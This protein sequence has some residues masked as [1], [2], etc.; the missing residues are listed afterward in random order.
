[1]PV[2]PP[3]SAGT[4]PFLVRLPG[5]DDVIHWYPESALSP[6]ERRHRQRIRMETM[7][8]SPTPEVVSKLSEIGQE[9]D[10]VQDALVTLSVLGRL[11]VKATGRAIPGL[12]WVATAADTLNVLNKFYPPNPLRAGKWAARMEAKRQLSL[13]SQLTAG[14][15]KQRLLDTLKTG[16]LGFGW[17]EAVQVLQT[18]DWLTG[19]G[20][21]LGPIFGAMSDTMF[22]LARG[23]EFDFTGPAEVI[24]STQIAQQSAR[25]D[26]FLG[27]PLS[28]ALPP[29]AIVPIGM[30]LNAL[31]W[32][33]DTVATP[34]QAYDKLRVTWPGIIPLIDL[35]TFAKPGTTEAEI[36][37]L[38]SPLVG[39]AKAGIIAVLSAFGATQKALTMGAVAAG[40]ALGWLGGYRDDLWWEDHVDLAMGSALLVNILRPYMHRT[41]WGAIAAD[42][43]SRPWWGGPLPFLPNADSMT[44]SQ[45]AAAL[46]DGAHTRPQAWLAQIPPG[47]TRDF[48]HGLLSTTADDHLDAFE[49]PRPPIQRDSGPHWR[50]TLAMHEYD[51]VLPYDRTDEDATRYIDR[52]AAITPPTGE[53]YPTRGELADIWHELWPA[54][55]TTR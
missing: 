26:Q 49:G 55:P 25:L 15:Y 7:R 12:G 39:P 51:L 17:G 14:T 48:A 9:I 50:A 18:S 36:T 35:A 2:G 37:D 16:K 4:T 10:N 38:L 11:G 43:G 1:M 41:D 29:T 22:G 53:G 3:G 42:A 33:P 32:L 30:M 47:L 31:G 19:V 34:A 44:T 21:S 23:A 40:R 6:A 5:W 8:R 46:R 52:T 13:A 54:I 45:V 27:A 28:S 20:L 24:A